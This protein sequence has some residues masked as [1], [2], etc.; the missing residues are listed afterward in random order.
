MEPRAAVQRDD[1]V[2]HQ[3]CE[4]RH[5]RQIGG[6]FAF[7]ADRHVPE[8]RAGARIVAGIQQGL[9]RTLQLGPARHQGIAIDRQRTEGRYRLDDPGR[10][11]RTDDRIEVEH[12]L[13]Q[14]PVDAV[15]ELDDEGAVTGR[16]ETHFHWFPW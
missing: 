3:P 11:V 4:P 9:D 2:R 7:I 16:Q 10:R 12:A 15:A 6:E 8:P 14:L 1:I 13:A 5:L